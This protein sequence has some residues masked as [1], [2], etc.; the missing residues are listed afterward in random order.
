MR[1]IGRPVVLGMDAGGTMTDTICVDERGNFTIGKSLTTPNDE[2]VGFFT[3]VDNALSYWDKTQDELFPSLE[4][5]VYAGTTMI[6]ALIT[7]RGRR[8][9]VITT[10][11]FEDDALIGRGVQVWKSLEYADRLHSA[12]HVPP[13]PLVSRWDIYGVTERV[14]SFG[15]IAVP[16]YESEVRE[17]ASALVESGVE[18]IVVHFLYSF[19]NDEHEL[20]AVEIAREIAGDGSEIEFYRGSYVRPVIREFERLNCS[21][22][23][24][25]AAAP[26]RRHLLKLEQAMQSRGFRY[27]MQTV[28]AYG[29]TCNVR[30]PRLHESVISGP[31]GGV[32]AAQYI[33]EILGEERII[34]T[35]LGGTSFDIAAITD[36]YV[37]IQSETVIAG[38]VVTLPTIDT[39][40][41]GAGAGTFIRIDPL[42]K[43]IELGPDGA[44]AS[45]GPVCFD[46][47]GEIL[48]I[49]DCDVILGYLDP[50][51]FLGGEVKLDPELA[52]KA[53][54]EQLADPLG[55]DAY[56]AAEAMVTM[57]SS[58]AQSAI[59]TAAGIRG[60][61][62]SDYLL[63]AYGGAGPVHAF[64][65]SAGIPFK[66]IVTFKFAAAFS[67]LGTTVGDFMH[68]Y[69]RS[70]PLVIPPEADDEIKRS[71]SEQINAVWSGLEE[72]AYLEMEREGVSR[73]AVTVEH[74]LMMRYAGQLNDLE[75]P[76]PLA[77]IESPE[78]LDR[79]IEVWEELYERI[80]RRVS[81]YEAAG[82]QV[83]E[84]GLVARTSKVKPIL[85]RREIEGPEP[86]AQ[87][88]RG[89]RQVYFGGEWHTTKLWEMDELRPGNVV[90]GPAVVEAPSTT[91]LIPPGGRA[92]VDEWEFLWLEHGEP[93]S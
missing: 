29:G 8:V 64:S 59:R 23:E 24:A 27:E 55:V 5:S 79:L 66:G 71:V 45:P 68:R 83:F 57:L 53:V 67:A 31:V 34:C 36:G 50:N 92:R 91:L 56:E 2:T 43:K 62:T 38:F 39:E 37:P 81:K 33:G 73:E 7:R 75:S 15:E 48:S 20:R 77:R 16:L 40:S 90:E 86:S 87:A 19:L 49:T 85:E 63:F 44:G 18:A 28:L 11:G 4:A 3:S 82:Y 84:L 74:L 69:S 25:Y 80:N 70:V 12:T 32:M 42:T 93:E 89:Q 72:E 6:N 26:S 35:D 21:L 13:T 78:D 10:K 52:M 54:K 41:I 51:Y 46:R 1:E 76:S 9:G 60:L 14:D 17:A 61:S 30:Y 47:G 22:I 65:Y 58:R 88:S